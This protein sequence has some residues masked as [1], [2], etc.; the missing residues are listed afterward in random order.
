[1][2]TLKSFALLW[3]VL[4]WRIFHPKQSLWLN[5]RNL[6][7]PQNSTTPH[8]NFYCVAPISREKFALVR[9]QLVTCQRLLYFVETAD[10]E[11]D[12]YLSSSGLQDPLEA[13]SFN[14]QATPPATSNEGT[15]TG[16]G[17]PIAALRFPSVSDLDGEIGGWLTLKRPHW[18]IV[19]RLQRAIQTLCVSDPF[20]VMAVP[21]SWS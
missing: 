1:M 11:T 21:S 7:C 2:K 10:C 9:L 6:T 20:K 15:P 19:P 17:F 8:W 4:F 18:E 12:G 5:H 3:C 16:N 13:A 14:S